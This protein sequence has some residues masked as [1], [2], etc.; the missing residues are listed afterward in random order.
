MIPQVAKEALA[1][2]EKVKQQAIIVKEQ[3]K[4]LEKLNNRIK[5]AEEHQ[6]LLDNYKRD[7]IERIE[8]KWETKIDNAQQEGHHEIS[9]LCT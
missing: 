7:E 1:N 9:A 3:E 4:R 6:N 2:E 8:S 5:I